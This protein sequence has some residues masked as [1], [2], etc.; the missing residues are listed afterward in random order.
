MGT[1][2]C[3]KPP[4]APGSLGLVQVGLPSEAGGSD[5][6]DEAGQQQQE[7][8]AGEDTDGEEDD[9]DVTVELLGPP[10]PENEKV[11]GR[12]EYAAH[13][14]LSIEA[15]DG[16]LVPSGW[17]TR[18]ENGGTGEP[19]AFTPGVGVIEGWTLGVL[20]MCEG[21][22]AVI[23]VPSELGYGATGQGAKGGAWHV[24]AG[25]NLHFDIE[26]LHRSGS[27]APALAELEG[28]DARW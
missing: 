14:T 24:P 6:G 17:S 13:V 3:E 11:S 18:E 21:E 22:R 12:F 19:F 10:Q 28:F 2:L 25:S 4:A 23:H 7:K 8:H 15:E 16:S 26:I 1:S 20:Q 9:L 27:I 5:G